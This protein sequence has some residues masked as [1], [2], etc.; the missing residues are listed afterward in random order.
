MN[1]DSKEAGFQQDIGLNR[2]VAVGDN[3][4]VP[5][6]LSSFCTCPDGANRLSAGF[7]PQAV[8]HLEVKW[9]QP[10]AN[11]NL[12]TGCCPIAGRR[13]PELNPLTHAFEI[14][15][16]DVGDNQTVI[17]EIEFALLVPP[18]VISH[19]NSI[20]LNFV[21]DICQ[22]YRFTNAGK[23]QFLIQ[24]GNLSQNP[25]AAFLERVIFNSCFVLPEN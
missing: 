19:R 10:V 8:P 18:T 9:P 5:L 11:L 24:P 14:L 25:I 16:A 17:P 6:K 3:H 21:V 20:E 15:A 7:V 23:V 1:A 2:W 4:T 13:W 22:R 12:A